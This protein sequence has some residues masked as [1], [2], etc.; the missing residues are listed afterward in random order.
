V[1]VLFVKAS[2][3]KRTEPR[4]NLSLQKNRSQNGGKLAGNGGS[5]PSEVFFFFRKFKYFTVT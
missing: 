2:V 4:L 1:L 5:P 3:I